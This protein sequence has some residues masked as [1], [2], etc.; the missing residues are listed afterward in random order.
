MQNGETNLEAGDRLAEVGHSHYLHWDRTCAAML[1]Q[2]AVHFPQH[3]FVWTSPCLLS[4]LPCASEHDNANALQEAS[5]ALK[6]NDPAGF[7]IVDVFAWWVMHTRTESKI[8]AA[9]C[10]TCLCSAMLWLPPAAEQFAAS[11]EKRLHGDTLQEE[12]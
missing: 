12:L 3:A 10:I 11:I 7:N 2:T 1:D 5:F 4:A 8:T 6:T 9:G